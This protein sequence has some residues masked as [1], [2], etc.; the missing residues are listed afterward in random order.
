MKTLK[1]AVSSTDGVN[2][3]MH[4]GSSTHFLIFEIN[5]KIAEF[6]EL[7]ENPTKHINEHKDR[8]NGALE[9]LKDCQIIFCS[10]IGDIPKS[11]LEKNGIKV[12]I[13][14]NTLKE[15]LKEYMFS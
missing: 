4:F 15:A 11:I 8:W 9:L 10:K 14:K 7:R 6:L 13:S 1:I 5:D 12:V 3:N 2:I